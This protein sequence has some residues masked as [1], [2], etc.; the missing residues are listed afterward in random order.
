MLEVS[1]WTVGLWYNLGE[2]EGKGSFILVTDSNPDGVWH[3]ESDCATAD[4]M[5]FDL[6]T[7]GADLETYT[8][9][10]AKQGYFQ[11][12]RMQISKVQIISVKDLFADPI[13][14]KLPEKI[15]PVYNM[16]RIKPQ[17][18]TLPGTSEDE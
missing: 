7:A 16:K 8:E 10:A 5:T 1:V 18:S 11:Y 2:H 17:E 14:L 4:G 9:W 3:P 12:V 13:P 15:I 6:P